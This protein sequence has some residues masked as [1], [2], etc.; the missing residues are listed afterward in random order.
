MGRN[1]IQ[2]QKGLSLSELHDTYGTEAQCRAAVR[3]WRWPD[4]FACPGCGSRDHTIVGR[5]ELFEC[6]DCLKQTSLT[7]GTIF[8]KTNVPLQKW[9]RLIYKMAVSNRG[10][11]L[12]EM[13]RELHIADYKTIWVMGH[14]LRHA[15]RH[16]DN[17]YRF[18]GLIELNESFIGPKS[19]EDISER[20]IKDKMIVLIAVYVYKD[21]D[22]IDKPG[23]AH[24]QIS[25]DTSPNTIKHVLE[26][27]GVSRQNIRSLNKILRTDGWK[28]YDKNTGDSNTKH[29]RSVMISPVN[30]GNLS[31]WTYRLAANIQAALKEAAGAPAPT[32][33]LQERLARLKK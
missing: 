13:Q 28:S 5:R 18:A 9:F 1:P 12:L 32:E 2:M 26:K 23:F 20:G 17:R 4:G 22:D 27:L 3:A 10:V 7:A 19:K 21:L 30:A 15:M 6:R 14:K 25:D 29:Y 33:S 31:P 24:A 11:S 8:H 16:S